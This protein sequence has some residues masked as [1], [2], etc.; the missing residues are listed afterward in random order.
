MKTYYR[1]IPASWNHRNAGIEE[2]PIDLPSG[3]SIVATAIKTAILGMAVDGYYK[4]ITINSNNDKMSYEDSIA[5]KKC[6]EYLMCYLD[7]H[8]ESTKNKGG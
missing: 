7:G 3:N 4:G 2:V 5:T 8:A 1:T 6:L